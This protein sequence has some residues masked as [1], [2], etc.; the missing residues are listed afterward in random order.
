M[1]L[2]ESGFKQRLIGAA[3][4]VA[5]AVLFLPA[6]LDGKKA[7]YYEEKIIPERPVDGQL[8]ELAASLKAS[9]KS[10]KT[11]SNKQKNAVTTTSKAVSPTAKPLTGKEAAYIVQVASFAD[12]NNANKLVARLKSQN[13]KAFVRKKITKDG[14]KLSQVLVGPMLLKSEAEVVLQQL[15]GKLDLKAV[16]VEYDPVK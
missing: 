7:Q 2:N 14:L 11:T 13:L 9:S 15:K 5:L 6:I 12:V 16:I 8:T 1:I 10:N 4:L 3:V